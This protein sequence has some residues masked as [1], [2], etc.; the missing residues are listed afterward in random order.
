MSVEWTRLVLLA[1]E[2]T[3]AVLFLRALI[4]Y[5]RR[6]D[7]LQ[8]DVTLVFAPCALAFGVDAL[9]QTIGTRPAL[10]GPLTALPLMAQPYLTLRLAGRLRDVP[11]VLIRGALVAYLLL[12]IPLMLMERPLPQWLIGLA[13]V[14]F[15]SAEVTAGLLLLGKARSRTGTN[16]A[17]LMTAGAATLTFGLMI[18]L[19]GAAAGGDPVLRAI[20]RILA[21]ASGLGYLI[22]FMPPR[23]LR[24]LSAV[25]A[26]QSM[27][28]RLL[29]APADAPEEV[30]Q[31]YA[32][33]MRVQTGADAVAV[34]LPHH[35]IPDGPL[36]QIAYA[37][38][39]LDVPDEPIKGDPGR[40][41]RS[42]RPARL[43]EG[44]PAL[45]RHFGEG[46]RDDFVTVLRMPVPPDVEGWVLLFNRHRSLFSDDD[47]GL[48]A[49]L[50][51]QAGI[52][53]ERQAVTARERRLA[54]ELSNSVEA[55]TRA[56]E[57]KSNFLAGMSHEL[58]TPLNAIIGFSDLM[59]LEEPE[60]DRRRVPADW[61]DHI[62]SSGRHLLGL[63]NDILDLAK[64]EAGRMDLRVA[65]V[66]VDTA[67]EELLTT[68]SPLFAQKNLT[69][70]TELAPVTALAD[71]LRLR[72]IVENLLSN[73]IKFT[74]PEGTVSITVTGSDT[75]VSVTVTD[76]GVGI[77][78]DDAERVFE[79]FQQV[80]DPDRRQAGTGLGL[81]LTRRLVEAQRGDI[82]LRSAPGHGSSFTVRL[83]AAPVAQPSAAGATNAP[84]V[85][86]VEDDPHSAELMQTQLS[87]AGYRVEVAGSGES[88]L[89]VAREHRPDAI[90]LDVELPGISGWEVIRQLKADAALAAVPVFF[91]SIL[92]EAAAGLALGAHDY[93]VKPVDQPALLSALSNAIAAR[94]APRVLVVDHDD[95]VRH[96]IEDGLRAGGADVVACADGRDGLARSREEHFDLIVCDMQ[97]P[98]ADGFS[99]LAAI[100]QDPAGR[101]TPVLGLSA[102]AL[103]EREPGD[104]A[105]LIATAMAGGVVAEA[106]AGGAGWDSLAPLLA[107]HPAAHHPALAHHPAHPAARRVHPP[108]GSSPQALHLRSAVPGGPAVSVGR[109]ADPARFF[110]SAHPGDVCAGPA[111]TAGIAPESS[112][113]IVPDPSGRVPP[114]EDL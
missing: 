64:V 68:L 85:L 51:G 88:G 80:G 61:V 86:L 63:I 54:A 55:L 111:Q 4:G 5:L 6:R 8:G 48:L 18:M 98:A 71:R 94:P 37:G 47:V 67:I 53:A 35:S 1:A 70:M 23:W 15:L 2:S 106:M 79:E 11:R 17:R 82:T 100:E 112:G 7:P 75:D 29:R 66:R 59:R 90:V 109:V 76:T 27:T 34:L 96:A 65:P 87:N 32:D 93:F 102:A 97:S 30:W 16:R 44:D 107:R 42:G 108:A 92:D 58:R 52:L 110:G 50:G 62:H 25:T 26:A 20:S 72:Q 24:R 78:D 69:V 43:R 3:F 46:L 38:P 73:A 21:L 84:Y 105:P 83:P 49:E 10:T 81:A 89:T 114:K 41:L 28:E 22:A 95:A 9:W 104:T 36:E 74:P 103:T 60:G 14:Y 31:T 99:L 77:A 45:I 33:L 113:S 39:P 101:H 91:A 12:A 57:A 13:V 56:N 19:V 40:L